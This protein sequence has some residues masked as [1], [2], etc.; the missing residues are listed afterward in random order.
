MHFA[1]RGPAS[2]SSTSTIVSVLVIFGHGSSRRRLR[3]FLPLHLTIVR[4]S[5]FLFRFV[6]ASFF[7]PYFQKIQHKHIEVVYDQLIDMNREKLAST[8]E[9]A[10]KNAIIKPIYRLLGIIIY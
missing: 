6:P 4:V 3:T 9:M 5:I 1:C 2:T 8:V 10:M 7:L